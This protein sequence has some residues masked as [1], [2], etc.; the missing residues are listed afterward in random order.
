MPGIKILYVCKNGPSMIRLGFVGNHSLSDQQVNRLSQ[1]E[2]LT[3]AGV[4]LPPGADTRGSLQ[5]LVPLL[6]DTDQL[7]ERCDALVFTGD[8]ADEFEYIVASLRESRHILIPNPVFLSRKKVDYLFKLAEEARVALKF[9]QPIHYHPALT[10]LARFLDKPEYI[11]IKR[12]IR[13]G[14][15]S[16][17]VRTGMTSALTECVDASLFANRTN[18]KKHKIIHLPASDKNPE[19][20]HTRLEM[21]NACIINIQLNRFPGDEAFEC[22]FYQNGCELRADLLNDEL[23]IIRTDPS[24]KESYRYERVVSPDTLVAEVLQFTGIIGSDGSYHSPGVNCLISF[25]VSSSSWHQLK[26]HPIP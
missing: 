3:L 20:I 22:I 7:F 15:D 16:D 18:L 1:H 26:A 25:Q 24:E 6:E 9:R 11:E 12:R 21:D 2:G 4:Y 8:P 19:M 14:R 17:S 5:H 13:P 10:G 23:N